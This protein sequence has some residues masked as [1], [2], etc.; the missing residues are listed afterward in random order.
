MS[1]E[2]LIKRIQEL[3]DD[4]QAFVTEE[5]NYDDMGVTIFT[6]PKEEKFLEWYFGP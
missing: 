6:K 5:G 2:E 1:K 3:P 4:I